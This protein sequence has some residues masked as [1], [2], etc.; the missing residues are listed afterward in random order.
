MSSSGPS[1]TGLQSNTAGTRFS[2]A[3]LSGRCLQLHHRVAGTDGFRIGIFLKKCSCK[4]L[5]QKSPVFLPGQE[6]DKSLAQ[7]SFLCVQKWEFNFYS[8]QRS[9]F[10]MRSGMGSIFG[11]YE[12]YIGVE[13][14]YGVVGEFQHR[15]RSQQAN[16]CPCHRSQRFHPPMFLFTGSETGRQVWWMGFCRVYKK[17]TIPD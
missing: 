2:H 12:S 10:L 14:C 17:G 8:P 6:C 5:N 1:P 7:A 11:G 3:A 4:S 15:Q 16:P 13:R 9:P